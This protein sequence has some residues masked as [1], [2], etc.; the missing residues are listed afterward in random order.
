CWVAIGMAETAAI[1][2]DDAEHMLVRTS[3]I[4]STIGSIQAHNRL[5]D[6]TAF[7]EAEIDQIAR[8]QRALLPERLPDIP[9]LTIAASYRTFDRAGGDYYDVFP[10]DGDATG[11]RDGRWGILIADASGHGPSAAVVAA[12]VNALLHTFPGS[13]N[14]PVEMLDYLNRHLSARR[15]D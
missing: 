2:W 3:L 14:N 1:N 13:P 9:G 12:M 10:L 8:L 15:L 5:R 7:I 11:A 4:N 6:A